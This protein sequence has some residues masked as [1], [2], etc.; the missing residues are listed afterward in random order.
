[1]QAQWRNAGV[2]AE[3]GDENGEAKSEFLGVMEHFVRLSGYSSRI[4]VAKLKYE[5][6]F[7]IARGRH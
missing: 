7:P 1:M 2:T 4:R 3:V 6:D 5:Q